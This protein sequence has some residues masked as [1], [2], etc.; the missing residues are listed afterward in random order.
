M[1]EAQEKSTKLERLTLNEDK[2][3]GCNQC[4]S[5]CPIPG[6]SIAYV[7]DN[8]NKVK[9]DSERLYSLRGMYKGL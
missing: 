1:I 6:A 5:H 3:V 7:E 8:V 9:V 2:C 4:I